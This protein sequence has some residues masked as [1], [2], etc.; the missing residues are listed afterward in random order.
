MRLLRANGMGGSANWAPAQLRTRA[1]MCSPSPSSEISVSDQGGPLQVH[2]PKSR[3]DNG[4]L[5]L[6][7]VLTIS[8]NI[9]S[10]VIGFAR[11]STVVRFFPIHGSQR[12]SANQPLCSRKSHPCAKR[13]PW[14]R[15]IRFRRAETDARSA[16]RAC[17]SCRRDCVICRLL[18]Y[19]SHLPAHSFSPGNL[20]A[21]F[22]QAVNC[23]SSSLSASWMSR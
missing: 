1:A 18:A 17:S 8:Q 13:Q 7:G 12:T 16:F 15:D 14:L 9:G 20:L 4:C 21:C 23:F 2:A 19:S 11:N 3:N 10:R 22:T 5:M 6:S